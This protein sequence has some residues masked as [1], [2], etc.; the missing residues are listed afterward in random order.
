MY[1]DRFTILKIEKNKFEIGIIYDSIC[2]T[3]YE[4]FDITKLKWLMCMIIYGDSVMPYTPIIL[5]Y[6]NNIKIVTIEQIQ[7]LVNIK[8]KDYPQFKSDEKGLTIKEQIL[9]EDI[10]VWTNNKWS[11]IIKVIRHKTLKNIY[12]IYTHQGIVDVTE[13]HSLI[14]EDGKLIKPN[15][16]E[17]GTKL[18]NSF[19]KWINTDKEEISNDEAYLLGI[20]I[21]CGICGYYSSIHEKKHIWIINN[22]S[23][24]LLEKCK[25]ILQTNYKSNFE[26]I[27]Y[28]T[29]YKLKIITDDKDLVIKYRNW[30]YNDNN[31]IIPNIIMNNYENIKISFLKGL[32]DS[33]YLN[34]NKDE[35]FDTLDLNVKSQITAQSYY[36][37]FNNLN[38]NVYISCNNNIYN[39]KCTKY[40]LYNNINSIIKIELLHNKYDGYVY[41]LETEEGIFHAGIGKIVVKNT[42]SIFI[43]MNMINKTTKELIINKK[44][45][46]WSINLG[47]I[48]SK[49]LKIH[50]PYPQN[51]EYEK[52]FYP[53]CI[54]AKK[55]YV[56]NKY[57]TDYNNFKQACMGI[58]LKRRDNPPIVKKIIG[59]MIDIMLNIMDIEQVLQYI[60]L[61]INN[62]FEGKYTI[63]N[64]ITSK[65]LKDGY[66]YK[67]GDIDSN[68]KEIT[69]IISIIETFNNIHTNEAQKKLSYIKQAHVQLAARMALRDPGN[70]PQ[71]ND[72][73]PYVAI[74]V[75]TEKKLLQG[76]LIEHPEYIIKNNLKIDYLFYLTNQ[77]MNPSI[78]FLEL[79]T[80]NPENIFKEY[81]DKIKKSKDLAIKKKKEDIYVSS[82]VNNY[83]FKLSD[84]NEDWNINIDGL[85][86]QVKETNQTVKKREKKIKKKI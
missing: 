12:R 36:M 4:E 15:K 51:M 11:K 35:N 14:T 6:N 61:A 74:Q 50:L 5:K 78:Q 70:K 44:S 69:K 10:F 82:M 67:D 16:C 30:C 28:N 49:L 40:Y 39:I 13:D 73:I 72:R 84:N 41:D 23:L 62:L 55:K 20:F 27:N 43:R 32:I 47:Q 24:E 53:F 56:G 9:P 21:N 22:K 45:L 48:A 26:I 65:A 60:K 76:D 18:M 68:G 8:W 54:L 38:Y 57:E 79:I 29:Y 75:E 46:E 25:K 59:G 80:E 58:V 33:N 2:S 85:I 52:T 17:I 37:F 66:K 34:L 86:N 81:I 71:L 19:P 63:R 3:K 7:G 83:G 77:I 64:F 42:D 31:K 1:D